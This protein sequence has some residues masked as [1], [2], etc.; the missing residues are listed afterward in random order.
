MKQ[1]KGNGN[2][3]KTGPWALI[4]GASSGIGAAFARRLAEELPGTGVR[5]QALCPGLTRTEFLDNEAYRDLD[6]S[7]IPVSSWMTAA[8]VA[9]ESMKALAKGKVVFVPGWRNRLFVGIM[10]TPV[11]GNAVNAALR[12]MGRKSGI[13][14]NPTKISP[15]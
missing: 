10:N 14:S 9:E 4:T 2:G 5:I 12:S 1:K 7:G 15:H 3:K 13:F 8:A 6:L 11:L